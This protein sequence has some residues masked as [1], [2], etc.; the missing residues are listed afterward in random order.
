MNVNK[1]NPFKSMNNSTIFFL[2]WAWS[3]F[4][5]GGQTQEAAIMIHADQVPHPVS[6]YLTGACIEDVN[7]EIYGGIDS[8]MIFGE[9][10]AEAVPQ[11][12]L[13][14]LNAYGGRWTPDADGKSAK[15][16]FATVGLSVKRHFTLSL[17]LIRGLA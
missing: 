2:A 8:Q 1:I 12:P 3:A 17:P 5:A 9:S 10:F 15:R 4:A 7:H 14:G 16:C 13:K 11:L 6:H